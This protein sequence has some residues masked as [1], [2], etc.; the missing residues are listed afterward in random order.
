MSHSD[1][2]D[3]LRAT[4][5]ALDRW[6]DHISDSTVPAVG[7]DL[8][9]MDARWKYAPP[10]TLAT[11]GVASARE[12]L[13]AVRLLIDAGEL[14][15]SAASTLCRAALVGAAQSVWMLAGADQTTRLQRALSLAVEDY[16]N[17]ITFG[18]ATLA[19]SDYIELHATADDQLARLVRRRSE[20]TAILD[21]LGGKVST[22]MTNDVLPA[23]LAATPGNE[24]FRAQAELRWRSMSG[25]AHSL[26]WQHFGQPGTT[27]E[28][29]DVDG[30][31]RVIVGGDIESL[32]MDYFTAFRV[33]AAGWNLLAERADRPDLVAN[34]RS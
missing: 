18:N 29:S 34:H 22:N 27:S 1:L 23:A 4:F 28:E 9:S 21:E 6:S 2:L 11:V 31:S 5:P 24:E 8:A 7:S 10:S 33:A 26:I 3:K 14:F 13:H 20:V 25:A 17:H 12:H 19:A 15:P 32:V 16:R 30:I